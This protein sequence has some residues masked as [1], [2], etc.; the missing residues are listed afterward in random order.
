[1]IFVKVKDV[2]PLG[3]NL[4]IVS[5]ESPLDDL[6]FNGKSKPVFVKARNKKEAIQKAPKKLKN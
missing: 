2:T 1:M 6:L 3:G 5:F 4:Y